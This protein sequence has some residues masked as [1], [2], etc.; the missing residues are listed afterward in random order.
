MFLPVIISLCVF[1]IPGEGVERVLGINWATKLLYD[2]YSAPFHRNLNLHN[3]VLVREPP[4]LEIQANNKN[5]SDE[6]EIIWKKYTNG[7]ILKNRDLRF[8]NFNGANLINAD[9]SYSNLQG[10]KLRYAKLINVN[11]SRAKLDGADL[12]MSDLR[13]ANMSGASAVLAKFGEGSSGGFYGA[14]L[15]GANFEGANFNFA[16]MIAT[17]LDGA[18]FYWA[19]LMGTCWNYCNLRASNF[20]YARLHGASFK[21]ADLRGADLRES[22]LWGVFLTNADLRG[23][24]LYEAKISNVD[25]CNSKLRLADFRNVDIKPQVENIYA[26]LMYSLDESKTIFEKGGMDFPIESLKKH[27]TRWLNKFWPKITK[28]PI[29]SD[30]EKILYNDKMVQ[31]KWPC[32]SINVNN[33]ECELISFLIELSKN[34]V[35]VSSG[36]ALRCDPPG[37]GRYVWYNLAREI[38]KLETYKK[39]FVFP[40]THKNIDLNQLLKSTQQYTVQYFGAECF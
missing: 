9:L 29:I 3:Q 40:C 38:L 4:P 16:A 12:V 8:A 13:G 19:R 36:L 32:L 26:H 5:F 23:A 30:S 11:L 31:L 35:Y 24:S 20:R 17:K 10:A 7:L 1:T 15:R 21:N 37:T 25:F 22:F 27:Y 39:S 2:S 18:N 28:L 34:D 33:Y 6:Y 14:D